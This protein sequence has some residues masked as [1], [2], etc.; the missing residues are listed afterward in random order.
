M[1]AS[2]ALA[3]YSAGLFI[4][5]VPSVTM[6]N[7]SMTDSG[8]HTTYNVTNAAHQAW[9][10]SAAFTTQVEYDEFQ[11]VTVTGGPTGG[12]FPLTFGANTTTTIA[13]NAAASVVQAALVALA[14]IGANNAVV[15]GANGGPWTVEFTGTLGYASQALLTKNAAGLT[16]GTSPNI[17]IARTQGGSTWTTITS[18][19]SLLYAIGQVAFTSVQ[20]ASTNVRVTGKYFTISFLA[21]VTSIDGTGT[22]A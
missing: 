9:D 21:G 20:S 15:T 3:G 13:Y 16:G 11:S 6:T 4:T 1:T 8:D 7:E 12:T 2:T 22:G 18:G 10:Y 5:S 19:F 14:S 17:A